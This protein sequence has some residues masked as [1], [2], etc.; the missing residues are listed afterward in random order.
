[1]L[2]THEVHAVS[3]RARERDGW[4]AAHHPGPHR[5]LP[6][7]VRREPAEG[8][9]EQ[10]QRPALLLG[11]VEDLDQLAVVGMRAGHQLRA[12]RDHGIVAR[13]VARDQVARDGPARRAAVEPPEE[14]RDEPPGDLR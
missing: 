1:M 4:L 8:A 7:E 3:Y 5:R 12:R 9:Q 2:G 13:K 10:P 6:G 14:Q 11:A